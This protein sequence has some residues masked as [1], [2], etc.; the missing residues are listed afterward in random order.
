MTATIAFQ[1]GHKY[2]RVSCNNTTENTLACSVVD[3]LAQKYSF[4]VELLEEDYEQGGKYW[5]HIKLFPPPE[6]P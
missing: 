5:R 3:W 2:G 4:R 6:T 1:I